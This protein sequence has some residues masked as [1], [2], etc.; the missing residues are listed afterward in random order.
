MPNEKMT[1]PALLDTASV[2]KR[3]AELLK[4]EAES[5]KQTLISLYNNTKLRECDVKTVISAAMY[6]ASMKLPIN[7]SL[8]LAHIIPYKGQAQFVIGYK[9][10]IQLALRTGQYRTLHTSPVCE[11]QIKEIDFVTGEVIRGRKISDKVVGYIAYM[12]L[13]NG[14]HRS[15][16]MGVDE[17]REHAKKYSQSYAYDLQT[18]R[19]KS[20]WSVNFDTMAKKTVLRK[21]L[22]TYAPI[23]IGH[24]D[25]ISALQ[26]DQSVIGEKT[27]TYPDNDGGTVEHEEFFTIDQPAAEEPATEIVNNETGEVMSNSQLI[28]S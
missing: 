9:G 25:M 18:G 28:F 4:G 6:A 7:P 17:I 2:Q 16:Y 14:F 10:F 11:G 12:E 5:F 13:K 26:A 20:I 23:S 27:F 21:L 8:G 15:V 1:L 22:N 3:F 24:E 19:Q